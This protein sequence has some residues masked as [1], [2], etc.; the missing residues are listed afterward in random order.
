M[1]D[2]LQRLF[3]FDAT[4]LA[5]NRRGVLSVKQRRNMEI[6]RAR[7]R[8]NP[9]CGLAAFFFLGGMG[10]LLMASTSGNTPLFI[11]FMSSTMAFLGS[12]L[13][14]GVLVQIGVTNLQN[15]LNAQYVESIEGYAHV[16]E[17]ESPDQ[18]YG[19]R[20]GG[21]VIR[22]TQPITESSI[23]AI[24]HPNKMYTVYCISDGTIYYILGIE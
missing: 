19:L 5:A 2:D 10:G 8:F 17:L 4:D 1:S 6:K 21:A 15:Q 14:I 13:M 9:T 23:H 18:G 16:V 7:L 12:I 20:L 3:Q 24:V 11:T 22:P